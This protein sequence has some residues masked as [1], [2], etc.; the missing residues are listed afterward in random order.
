MGEIGREAIKLCKFLAEF[1]DEALSESCHCTVD[2]RCYSVSLL[3]KTT[4]SVGITA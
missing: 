1:G 4:V 2:W 3:S